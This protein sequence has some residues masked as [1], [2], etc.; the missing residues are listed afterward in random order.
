MRLANRGN[1][2]VYLSMLATGIIYV[3]ASIAIKDWFQYCFREAKEWCI[4]M[5]TF[6]FN[7]SV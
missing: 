3:M 5:K 7:M 2:D 4:H 6:I 1:P